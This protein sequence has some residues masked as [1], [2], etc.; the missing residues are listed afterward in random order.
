MR[1]SAGVRSWLLGG[2]VTLLMAACG[3]Q[4]S[5]SAGTQTATAGATPSP[6][7][8]A[9]LIFTWYG[10][11]AN[12]YTAAQTDTTA[13]GTSGSDIATVEAHCQS[14]VGDAQKL[15]GDPP[16]PTSDGNSHWQAYLTD[17][18]KAAEEC[19]L[20]AQQSDQSV[21]NQA[22]LDLTSAVGEENQVNALVQQGL[23]P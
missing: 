9:S 8:S 18:S 22:L 7:S 20:G 15:H 12:D 14:L 10:T 19:V 23:H 5:S 17:L 6:T 21:L 2:G 4:G 13:V 3:A 11:V 16:F 1:R